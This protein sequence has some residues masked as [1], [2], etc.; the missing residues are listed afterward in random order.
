MPFVALALAKNFG[1]TFNLSLASCPKQAKVYVIADRKTL[2]PA[3]FACEAF[4]LSFGFTDVVDAR[5]LLV[6]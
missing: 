3:E 1:T 5:P 6:C 2:F 4:S